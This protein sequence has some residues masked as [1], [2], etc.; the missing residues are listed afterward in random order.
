M[1]GQFSPP[2]RVSIGK[3]GNIAHGVASPEKAAEILLEQWPAP[4]GPK[5]LAARKAVLRAMESAYTTA[6]LASARRAFS[7]A[8]EEAGIL[9]PE[10][11]PSLAPKS[12]R[13]PE[14]TQPM[15][16]IKRDR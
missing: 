1:P 10:P 5:H 15:R 11:P 3:A 14:W 13:T 12:F 6:T 8:A 9:L 4:W 7:E 2:V 16:P